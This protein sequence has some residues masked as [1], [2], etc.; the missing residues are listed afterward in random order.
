[1]THNI[2]PLNLATIG[3]PG[4]APAPRHALV[5]FTAG[6]VSSH[7]EARPAV[8]EAVVG[9]KQVHT[10]LSFLAKVGIPR[11]LIHIWGTDRG[12]GLHEHVSPRPSLPVGPWP[13]LPIQALVL[14]PGFPG[15]KAP[16][17]PASSFYHLTPSPID[18]A[19]PK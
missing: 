15:M 9:P 18:T 10:A 12:R 17:P 14:G 2:P 19:H 1:M 11:T 3:F 7:P 16:T 4:T 5:T 6:P 13:S 8:R